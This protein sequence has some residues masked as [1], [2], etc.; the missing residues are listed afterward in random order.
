M[1][2]KEIVSRK[3]EREALF[4][5]V[6]ENIINRQEDQKANITSS[7]V[8]DGYRE[9]VNSWH[10][11]EV[12]IDSLMDKWSYNELGTVEKALL[13]LALYEIIQLQIHYKIVI[14]EIVE[15]AKKYGDYETPKFINGVLGKVIDE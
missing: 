14:N 8:V 5:M 13:H 15:L 1:A 4:L 6:F 10:E 9:I 12:K 11:T 3:K 2:K 7:Y